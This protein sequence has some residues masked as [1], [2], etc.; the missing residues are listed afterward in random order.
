ME[1]N[2]GRVKETHGIKCWTHAQGSTWRRMSW[3]RVETHGIKCWTHTLS[4][5]KDELGVGVPSQPDSG[6]FQVNQIYSCEMAS[7]YV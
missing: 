3:G 4:L 6:T 2:G 5:E 1:S 7:L